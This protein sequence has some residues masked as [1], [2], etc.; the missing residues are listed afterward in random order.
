[1][2]IREVL[3][4]VDLVLL[5]VFIIETPKAAL[6]AAWDGWELIKRRELVLHDGSD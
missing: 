5:P 1:M 3:L 6:R 4:T 2:E